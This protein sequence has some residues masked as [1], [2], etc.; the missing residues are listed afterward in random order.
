[1]N[2]NCMERA[3]R[4]GHNMRQMNLIDSNFSH[5]EG[6]CCYCSDDAARQIRQTVRSLPLNAAHFLGSGDCHYLSLFWV[7]LIREPFAL[8]LFDNHPDDQP[9]AFGSGILSCGSWVAEARKLPF[10]KAVRWFDGHGTWQG[11]EIPDGL[12]VYLSVDLDVL[13]EEC[14][15]TDW[16]QGEV[17][18]QAL[19]EAVCETISGRRVIGAD[20]CGGPSAES[21][22]SDFARSLELAQILISFL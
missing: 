10:C 9:C 3:I 16:D 17:S 4:D 8:V 22:N 15:E 12:P 19:Q 7:E 20:I 1:M 21:G 6:T 5:I 11:D 18:V 13:S 14:I 2:A